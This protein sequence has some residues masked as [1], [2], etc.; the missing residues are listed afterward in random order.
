[1]MCEKCWGD[2]YTRSRMTHKMQSDCYLEI[3]EERKDNPCSPQ[4]QAGQFWDDNKQC[5][6]RLSEDDMKD[7]IKEDL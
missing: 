1:M 6:W 2:A 3:L 7:N 5:D 4:K